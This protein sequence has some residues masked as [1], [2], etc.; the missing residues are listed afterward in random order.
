MNID[1]PTVYAVKHKNVKIRMESRSGGIFTA[2]S[3]LILLDGG[4]IYGCVL[5]ENF[6]AVHIRAES[7]DERNRMRGSKYIQR[8]C[9]FLVHLVKWPD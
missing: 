9:C 8:R 2:L 3:D 7:I 1:N 5:T 6:T 4:I